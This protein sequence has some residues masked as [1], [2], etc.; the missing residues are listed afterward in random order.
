MDKV[1]YNWKCSSFDF[2]SSLFS[3][4]ECTSLVNDILDFDAPSFCGCPDSKKPEV[5][6]LCPEGSA[7]DNPDFVLGEWGYTCAELARSIE[8]I[9]TEES[10][11]NILSSY[12]EQG[13]INHCCSGDEDIGNV[14]HSSFSVGLTVVGLSLLQILL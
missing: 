2:A 5:C 8:Y 10:C 11:N 3:A 14:M 13:V 12:E 7:L 1:F 6:S 9:P 4:E